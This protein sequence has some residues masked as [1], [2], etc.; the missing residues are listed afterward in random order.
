MIY[1]RN[2]NICINCNNNRESEILCF[3]NRHFAD[4]TELCD[5][6]ILGI[7]MVKPLLN[8]TGQFVNL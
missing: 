5:F 4:L 1:N 8:L 2:N 7:I 6:T 3:I